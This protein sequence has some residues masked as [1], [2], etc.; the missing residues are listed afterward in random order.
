MADEL[1]WDN[2]FTAGQL[3]GTV[4]GPAYAGAPSFLRRRYTKDLTNA[5]VAVTGVPFDTA[6]TNRPGSRFG[7]RAVRAASSIMCWTSPWPWNFDPQEVLA[8]ADYGDCA[9][10]YARPQ[11]IPASIAEHV[12][13]ILVQNCGAL[14]IGGDHFIT[15]PV[16]Q[17]YAEKYGPLSLI[18]FDA[19]TDTWPD[20]AGG[21]DHGTMFYHAA[22]LGLVDPQQSAQ[23][24]IRTTNHDTLGFHV[25]DARQV[26]GSSPQAIAQQTKE[27]VGNNPVYLTF[28]IDCLDPAFAP[29]TGT[30]VPGGLS[31]FQALEIIRG[32]VGI[33]LVGMDVVEVAPAYD[34]GEITALAGATIGME[35]LCLFAENPARN[36][37]S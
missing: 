28:D 12:R 25:L 31:S 13:G 20:E 23:I 2:A 17:A 26:H 8:I 36:P 30:P 33:N 21:V 32:L 3:K 9:F 19:H 11:T 10:D 14:T 6:T 22:K 15:Y 5:D 1:D 27:I 35:L 4:E 24:G 18:H 7:P 16:L 34:V 37:S 29:G